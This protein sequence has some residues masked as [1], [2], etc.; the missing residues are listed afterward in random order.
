MV[1]IDIFSIIG[2][3]FAIGIYVPRNEYVH[4]IQGEC[5]RRIEAH[6]G[7]REDHE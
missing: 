4:K 5:L 6:L 2:L 3:A 7:L 1:G